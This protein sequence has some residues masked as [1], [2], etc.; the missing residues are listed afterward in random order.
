M[1]RS[2]RRIGEAWVRQCGSRAGWSIGR[3]TGRGWARKRGV[4]ETTRGR[5]TSRLF[6]RREVE[7]LR[8]KQGGEGRGGE[9][10][11]ALN[12]EETGG[13]ARGGGEKATVTRAIEAVGEEGEGGF[14]WMAL[15]GRRAGQ[16]KRWRWERDGK[17]VRQRVTTAMEERSR[18]R[19]TVA[20]GRG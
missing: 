18:R 19:G 10:G 1:S 20:V 2:R 7:R 9:T 8:E 17:A 3:R 12:D 6:A 4:V 5:G 13:L 16:V 14:R 15:G 11:G